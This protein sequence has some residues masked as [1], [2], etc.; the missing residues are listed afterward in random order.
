MYLL[1]SMG[2]ISK[3]FALILTLIIAISS[4]SVIVKPADAQT[5]PMPSI[6]EF[7]LR[8]VDASYTTS[9]VNSYNGQTETQQIRNNSVEVII[10]NQLFNYA[11]N[12][13]GVY[14]NVRVKP[15]FENASWWLEVYQPRT[16]TSLPPDVNGST[17]TYAWYL[18]DNSPKQ[19][20]EQTS[21]SFALANVAKGYDLGF[22]YGYQQFSSILLN[23][24]TDGQLD[25]QVQALV[26]HGSERWAVL[27]HDPLHRYDDTFGFVPAIAYD[28]ASGW[29][30][31]QT[32]N[33][34]DGSVANANSSD[35]TPITPEL[36]WLII[37]SFIF[38]VLVVTVIIRHRKTANIE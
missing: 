10:K 27:T 31:I 35:P 38:A 32:I 37:V 16:S 1:L 36:F 33:L 19:S 25:F 6:P 24:P 18:A 29:S 9:T 11:N 30:N 4:P 3:T 20:G 14:F 8:F 5:I 28:L 23:I 13:Y 21:V 12:S 34:G 26:G 7:T 2:K 15:H 22:Y 17:Y